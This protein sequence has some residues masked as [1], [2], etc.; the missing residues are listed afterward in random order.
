MK[1]LN[2]HRANASMTACAVVLLMAAA[3]TFADESEEVA[4][5]Y[6]Q[7]NLGKALEQA[8]AYLATRPKDAQMR[9]QKG[10]ILTEQNRIADATKVFSSLSEEYPDLPEP[11]NNLAVLYASQGQYDKAKSALEAAIRTHPSYSTA[12]ENLGDIY[13]K[14]ASQAYGKALQLDK[15]NA[16]AQTKLAMI[17]E[18]VT[19]NRPKGVQ[20]AALPAGKPSVTGPE[21]IA[22]KAP[23]K[24]PDNIS[25][26]AEKPVPEKAPL[27]EKPASEKPAVADNDSKEILKAINAWAKAWSDKDAS[28]YL[29]FY[30]SDFHTPRGTSRPAWEK[31]RRE[32]IGKPKSIHVEITH[33][34]ISFTNTA[35]ATVSFRQSY[36]SD[37]IKSTTTKTIEMVKTGEKWLI[38]QEQV[39]R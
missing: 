3:A 27:A 13:A 20:P 7:G 6:K 4:K 36:H 26:T 10:L 37:A 35:H 30:A 18:L 31:S 1:S 23:E 19:T 22:G 29:A 17:K 2:F 24:V 39:G 11:Y 14:M 9:F 21:K 28:T 38:Q 12:H 34:K 8:D 15:S 5:L 33:P 25:A 32:R 16:T